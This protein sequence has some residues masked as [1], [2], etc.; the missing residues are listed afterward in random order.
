MRSGPGP[1]E[2]NVAESSPFLQ[3]SLRTWYPF[4][5]PQCVIPSFFAIAILFVVLGGVFAN[6]SDLAFAQIVRY[7]DVNKYQLIPSRPL[8]NIQQGLKNFSVGG[9]T[10]LQGTQTK[11]IFTLL[12]DLPAP[13]YLYYGLTNFFQNHRNFVQGRNMLQL[14]GSPQTKTTMY[15]CEP[16][17]SPSASPRV[18]FTAGSKNVTAEDMTYSPC[19]IAPWSM[20]NDTF[21]LR[22]VHSNTTSVVICNTSDFDAVGNALGNTPLNRCSKKGISWDS[23]IRVRFQPSPPDQLVWSANYAFNTTNEYL[24]RGYYSQEPGHRIPDPLDLDFHVWM[25]VAPTSTFRK[26]LRI[27]QTN[28]SAGTY[29][30]DVTEFYDSFSFSGEKNFQLR[31]DS[32]V[33]AANYSLAIAYLAAGALAFVIGVAFLVHY[34][35]K[36]YSG[37]RDAEDGRPA[38]RFPSDAREFQELAQ[39]CREREKRRWGPSGST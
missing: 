6:R 22:Q 30:M 24:A 20:F 14:A 18:M 8:V 28:L 37:Q 34:I 39:L 3:Q 27:I 32:S 35:V 36:R 29:A 7:D 23:D 21:V 33:G 12:K 25:R 31:I 17:L 19:G 16:Y 38:Y 5:V 13:V 1:G 11:I 10:S 4:F 15:A 9:D 26:L 2:E